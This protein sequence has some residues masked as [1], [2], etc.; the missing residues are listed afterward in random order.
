MA[1]GAD[2]PA[3]LE[4]VQL[5]EPDIE[6]DQVDSSAQRPVKRARPVRRDVDE[7]T[8]TPQ[9]AGKWPCSSPVPP[10]NAG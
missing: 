10:R 2:S 4:P 3:H 1:F 6:N 5:G 9:R 8:L 7:I